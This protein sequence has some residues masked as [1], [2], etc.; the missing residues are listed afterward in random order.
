MQL[1]KYVTLYLAKGCE[2]YRPLEINLTHQPSTRPQWRGTACFFV[3]KSLSYTLLIWKA[4][5]MCDCCL[6]EGMKSKMSRKLKT[7][8][9][10][11][12]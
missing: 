3:N 11:D 4:G 6:L 5:K 10:E 8:F 9:D 12:T 7:K 2:D 1:F